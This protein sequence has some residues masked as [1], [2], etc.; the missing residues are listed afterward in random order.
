VRGYNHWVLSNTLKEKKIMGNL[1]K[2]IV[3]CLSIIT[4]S[5]NL[6]TS[7]VI[8][9]Q[10]GFIRLSQG[11]ASRLVGDVTIPYIRALQAGDVKALQG[12][13]AG[14]LAITIGKLLSDNQEY[15][16][17][18]REKFGKIDLLDTKFTLGKKVAEG[19][20]VMGNEQASG[21]LLV[22][23]SR[24]NNGSLIN[25]ELSLEKNKSGNWK[26]VDQKIK[27]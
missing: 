22:E 6:F 10:E 13:I 3:R 1:I 26:V 9:A 21:N 4:I 16:N 11:E 5:L 7:P 19:F 20:V 15:P 23:M 17:F 25:L 27:M 2:R 12:L 24:A 14:K 8:L 18:L